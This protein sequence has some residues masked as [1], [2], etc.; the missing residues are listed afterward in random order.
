MNRDVAMKRI[1]RPFVGLA[2]VSGLVLSVTSA[3]VAHVSSKTTSGI[4]IP[5]FSSSDLTASPGDN[6]IV[7]EGNLYGQ[8][9]STL[10]IVTPSNVAGM[11]EAWHVKL[12]ESITEPLLQLPG[13]APQLE[14]NGTTFAE[15]E[16]GGVFA[17]NAT[18]GQQVWVY[19]PD[20]KKLVI[21]A[22]DQG[23][24]KIAG[25]WAST[26]GLAMGDGKI[27]AE[28]QLGSVIALNA[29]TGK[30]IWSTQIAP[31]Y[32]GI[33]MSQPPQYYDGMILGATSG[34]D[35]GFPCVVFAILGTTPGR[36]R[37]P[38]T[39]E[40]PSGPRSGSIRRSGSRTSP[41][42]T[43]FRTVARSAAPGRSGS[44]AANLRCTS[45]RA[46]SLGSS[47]KCTMTPGTPTSRSKACWSTSPITA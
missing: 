6:W 23:S 40:Q 14:Y 38:M 39:A 33:G 8:R 32:Q 43:R 10:S 25:P 28:E 29:S 11:T 7:Q 3:A 45:A 9:H 42:G 13:E 19:Q 1:V 41:S 16:Y 36:T 44:P 5:N 20:S 17:L 35:T 4:S 24:F 30:R 21:P 18:T 22:K 31:A 15:D 27:F 2:V 46:S 47:R 26:R 12:S 37:S 34:G